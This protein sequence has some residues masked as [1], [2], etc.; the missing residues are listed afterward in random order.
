MWASRRGTPAADAER[1]TTKAADPPTSRLPPGPRSPGIYQNLNWFFR[2][3]PFIEKCHERYGNVF[4]VGLGPK[5]NVVV[6]AEP[7]LATQLITGDAEVYRAGDANGILRPVVGPSSL[8]VIDGDEHMHHRRILLPAFGARH[9]QSF[10]DEVQRIAAGRVESWTPGETLDL[11]P[12]M[13]KISFEAIM[14]VALGDEPPERLARLRSLIP[15]MMRRCASPFTILPYFRRELGGITPYARL[16][17]VLD[18]LDEIFFTA[19]RERRAAG[20]DMSEAGDALSLLIAA[21][22]Q[23]GDPLPEREIRDELLTLVMAGYETTTSALAWAFERLLR[24]PDALRK[25]TESLAAGDD[26][27]LDA[28]VM[29]T[30]RLRPV[31]PVV[32]RKVSEPVELG[33]YGIPAGTVLMASIYLMHRDPQLFSDPHAFIPERFL[34][35]RRQGGAWIPFGGGVRRCLGA[36]FAQLEMKV[37]LRTVFEAATLRAVDLEPEPVRR[38]R[39]TFAPARQARALVEARVR[40]S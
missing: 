39:F 19:I 7:E 25:L 6:V 38:K 40:A 5:R 11:E 12:E 20:G 28:V 29:E 3:I 21:T 24:S 2:P 35:A 34:E 30:L 36:S 17:R 14:R 31:V 16:R 13:E 27:Y 37:V 22:D 23:D 18:E 32:A 15:E 10:A 33:E 26:A 8:L 4:T 1:R 9:A